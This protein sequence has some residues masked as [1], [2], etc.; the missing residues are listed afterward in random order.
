ML[1]TTMNDKNKLI[2]ETE[3]DVVLHNAGKHS[4]LL[5]ALHVST[6]NALL[7]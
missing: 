7:L 5:T 3:L 6:L 2:S 1:K 4:C